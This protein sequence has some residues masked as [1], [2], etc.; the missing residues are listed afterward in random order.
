M[1]YRIK[2]IL[3]SGLFCACLELRAEREGVVE[4]GRVDLRRE[5]VALVRGAVEERDRVRKDC[6]RG[7][8]RVEMGV[9]GA[10]VGSRFGELVGRG[11]DVDEARR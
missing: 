6:R 11:G 7:V 1:W 3:G 4:K 8:R 9:C 10:I 2:V 5:V